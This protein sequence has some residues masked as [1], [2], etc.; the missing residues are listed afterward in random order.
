[1]MIVHIKRNETTWET[2]TATNEEDAL[3]KI[4]Q[5]YPRATRDSE[6]MAPGRPLA[7]D[8]AMHVYEAPRASEPRSGLVARIRE[9]S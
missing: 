1:M 4:R 5:Q 7:A 9:G 6:G 2:F 8:Q 3:R